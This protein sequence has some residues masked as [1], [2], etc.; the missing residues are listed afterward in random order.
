[1]HLPNFFHPT[2]LPSIS[3]YLLP[4]HTLSGYFYPAPFPAISTPRTL[5]G[6]FHH[7]R[8]PFPAISTPRLFRLSPRAPGY[9]PVPPGYFH[10]APFPAISIHTSS[11]FFS[12]YP[13]DSSFLP[14]FLSALPTPILPAFSSPC[15]F[16]N[17]FNLHDP[18]S[19][20]FLLS[21]CNG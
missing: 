13:F 10:P 11:H 4:T 14:L 18:L 20:Y 15:F 3:N 6:Y 7:P 21:Q 17:A 9:P 12:S 16:C 1:M 2:F 8:A 5:P 19:F